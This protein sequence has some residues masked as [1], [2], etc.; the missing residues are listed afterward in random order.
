MTL[1]IRPYQPADAARALEICIAAFTPIHEGFREALGDEIF[2]HQYH[3]WAERYAATFAGISADD[4][5]FVGETDGEMAGF[6]FT[7]LDAEHR[8]GELGLNAID[9][10]FQGRGYGK[11]LYRFAFERLKA[12]GARVAYAGTG[13]D[14][15]HAPARAAYASVGFDKVIPTHHL[16]RLL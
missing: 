12:R 13:G 2:G 14:A 15:A 4:E 6:I 1:T 8:T 5:V 11:A 3:G 7:G 9:P 10:R 16:F